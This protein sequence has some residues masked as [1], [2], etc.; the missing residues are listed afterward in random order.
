MIANH[1]SD[2]A[3][4]A[5]RPGL[6]G[7]PLL[8]QVAVSHVVR[9]CQSIGDLEHDAVEASKDMWRARSHRPQRVKRFGLRRGIMGE[10]TTDQAAMRRP[11]AV[12]RL[13]NLTEHEVSLDG[14]ATGASS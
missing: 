14:L 13:V 6:R 1:P 10:P 5:E 9:T 11:P 2:P 4:R 7:A 8:L 12:E 3:F